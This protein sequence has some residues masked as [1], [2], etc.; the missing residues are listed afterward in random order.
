MLGAGTSMYFCNIS[1]LA[2]SGIQFTNSNLER[3]P[4]LLD[5]AHTLQDFARNYFLRMRGK[6]RRLVHCQFQSFGG[7]FDML[8]ELNRSGSDKSSGSEHPSSMADNASK[9]AIRASFGQLITRSRRSLSSRLRMPQVYQTSLDEVILTKRD[10]DVVKKI[11]CDTKNMALLSHELGVPN[12]MAQLSR[13]LDVKFD[14]TAEL[15][16]EAIQSLSGQTLPHSHSIQDRRYRT[17]QRLS[18]LRARADFHCR[19]K[20]P[21]RNNSG[22]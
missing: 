8:P 2:Q 19:R 6:L 4:R 20:R 12:C 5:G 22:R 13:F 15:N 7:H 18:K 17:I 21:D 16:N 14:W 1:R 3:D 11:L 9:A 10:F